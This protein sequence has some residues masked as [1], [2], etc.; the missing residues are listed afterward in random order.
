MKRRQV[1]FPPLLQLT[2]LET[3][4]QQGWNG[5]GGCPTVQG[6]E[7]ANEMKKGA[8]RISKQES[9][10]VDLQNSMINISSCVFVDRSGPAVAVARR[11]IAVREF[12]SPFASFPRVIPLPLHVPTLRKSNH[13]FALLFPVCFSFPVSWTFKGT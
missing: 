2:F 9:C 12:F 13:Y 1:Y 4:C 10:D 11:K 7:A 3:S 8:M 5:L 6:R